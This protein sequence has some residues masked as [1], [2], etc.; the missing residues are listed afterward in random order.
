MAESERVI[1]SSANTTVGKEDEYRIIC[2]GNH[3]GPRHIYPKVN[4]DVA[5]RAAA[6]WD[7]ARNA[8]TR[9]NCLPMTVQSR[10]VTRWTTVWGTTW[11]DGALPA[12]L[13]DVAADPEL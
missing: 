5:T 2:A 11:E 8:Y 9:R 4:F 13:E 12:E 6:Q 10:T 1:V 3:S 7:K